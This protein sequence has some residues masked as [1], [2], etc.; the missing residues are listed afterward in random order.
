MKYSELEL[1]RMIKAKYFSIEDKIRF[2]ILNIIPTIH[3]I[4]R[5]VFKN[6]LVRIYGE[7][8]MTFRKKV[9]HVM[10]FITAKPGDD[11]RPYV[12]NDRGYELLDV[13]L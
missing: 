7:L 1:K 12:F 11:E 3:L 13:L 2:N 8:P 9:G 6:P 4:N 10:G 5:T